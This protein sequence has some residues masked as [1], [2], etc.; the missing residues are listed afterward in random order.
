MSA[1]EFFQI[2]TLF[3]FVDKFSSPPLRP[4]VAGII[5]ERS[6][7]GMIVEQRQVLST[8]IGCIPY[9][10]QISSPFN[11]RLEGGQ[12]LERVDFK[13]LKLRGSEIKREQILY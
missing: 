4:S 1:P 10:L 12:K 5:S 7:K 13:P 6:L 3:S 8:L 11:F 2:I 9:S